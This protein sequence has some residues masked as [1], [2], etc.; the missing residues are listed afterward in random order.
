MKLR[1]N[2]KRN[3][4]FLFEVLVKELTKSVIAEDLKRKEKIM[5]LIKKHFKR[6]TALF[7]EYRLYKSILE[8][9]KM[10]V[11][12]AEKLLLEVKKRFE[13]LDKKEIFEQQSVLISEVNKVLSKDVFLNF[14]SEYKNYATIHQI[15]N[16]KNDPRKQI[17]LE[18]R[19]IEYMA[20]DLQEGILQQQVSTDRLVF[21][22]FI[23]KFNSTYSQQ[24]NENQRKLLNKY[25][26]SFSDNGLEF[27][28]YLNEEIGRLKGTI[29]KSLE[30]ESIK[31]NNVLTEKM[32]MLLNRVKDYRKQP[33][34]VDMINEIYKL[35]SLVSE[36]K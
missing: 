29:T 14:V 2:K 16:K 11:N 13:K 25:I 21:K 3:T 18:Q 12:L 28:I 7:E 31:E 32:T 20:S 35:Q 8:S 26:A 22:S 24:L 6:G 15:L 9:Q 10:S 33:I 1:H 27:K 23:E 17:I 4:I 19:L 36:I 34:N 30:S 5:N